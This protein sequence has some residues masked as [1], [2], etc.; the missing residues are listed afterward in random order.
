MTPGVFKNV[1]LHGFMSLESVNVLIFDEC[2]RATGDDPYVGIMK[3]YK[4]I[5][6]ESRPLILGLTASVIN[7]QVNVLRKVIFSSLR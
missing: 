3:I 6:A 1:L 5:P 2:H 7:A 4:E